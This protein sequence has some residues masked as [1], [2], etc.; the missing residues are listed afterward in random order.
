[1]STYPYNNHLYDI[2]WD[3]YE[4]LGV[5]DVSERNYKS[6]PAEHDVVVVRNKETWEIELIL[7]WD[8]GIC[9]DVATAPDMEEAQETV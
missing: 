2:A 5:L 1:M 3:R 8:K 7:A 9:K 4:I 6:L